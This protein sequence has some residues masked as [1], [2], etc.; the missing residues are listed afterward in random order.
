MYT[1][2]IKK[3][4]NKINNI[5]HIYNM[6]QYSLSFLWESDFTLEMFIAELLCGFED[7]TEKQMEEIKYWFRL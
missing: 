2:D 1:E 4:S 3:F 6:N 5:L 7:L